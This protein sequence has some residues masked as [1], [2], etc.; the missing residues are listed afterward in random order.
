M[1]IANATQPFSII[2]FFNNKTKINNSPPVTWGA[3]RLT[4][5][6]NREQH[7][8]GV[9][10]RQF[11]NDENKFHGNKDILKASHP[12]INDT[13]LY[14]LRYGSEAISG[15]KWLQ[16]LPPEEQREARGVLCAVRDA[17][18]RVHP[19]S[20]QKIRFTA[21]LLEAFASIRL[22]GFSLMPSKI[23]SGWDDSAAIV[24][25]KAQPAR[26][27]SPYPA[28]IT[29]SVV[30]AERISQGKIKKKQSR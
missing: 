5:V 30:P 8:E 11:K 17:A 12:V 10:I 14:Y 13:L 27:G 2:S 29:R 7:G 9:T 15:N 1:L 6:S 3:H 26:D 4:N 19:L 18:E 21:A 23:Y 24:P 20:R 25:L 16:E 22:P 28:I